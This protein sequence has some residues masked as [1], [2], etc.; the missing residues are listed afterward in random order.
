MD[1]NEQAPFTRAE[2]IHQLRKEEN[3]FHEAI[4]SAQEYSEVT[5]IYDRIKL[6]YARLLDWNSRVAWVDFDE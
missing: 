3:T 2:L 4:E 1:T 5:V 6:I